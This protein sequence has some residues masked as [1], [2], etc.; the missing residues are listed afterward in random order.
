M[1]VEAE[2]VTV[3]AVPLPRVV[4]EA[5]LR[6]GVEMVAGEVGIAAE[7]TIK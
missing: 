5:M 2:A 7:V 3:G 1:A 4:E 6:A